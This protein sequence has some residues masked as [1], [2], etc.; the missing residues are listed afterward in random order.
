MNLVERAKAI[1]LTPQ[2]EWRAIEPESG[3]PAYLFANYVAI[4]AAIPAVCGFIGISIIGFGM[5][6]M[7]AYRVG[8]FGGIG[9]AILRYLLSFVMVYVIALVID[10]LA[11]TF[12]G[13]KNQSNALKLAVYSMTPVWLS[14]VFMLLPGFRWLGILGLYSL[15]LFWLGVPV[16]MK[17]PSDKSAPYTAAVVVCGIVIFVVIGA[18]LGAF[19]GAY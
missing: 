15:Y 12:G 19:S 10:A 1:L 3:D 2:T 18:V 11:P 4:L 14:G 17:A 6:M 8:F 9:H 5:P 7:G 13:Q 16:L